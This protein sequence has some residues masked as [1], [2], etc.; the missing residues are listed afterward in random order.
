MK[1]NTVI[2]ILEAYLTVYLVLAAITGVIAGFS[3]AGEMI[4]G[5]E[6]QPV[7]AVIGL[8]LAALLWPAFWGMFAKRWV[9]K[10]DGAS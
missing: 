6:E 3:V 4:A 1:G 2:S 10:D 5:R 8:V 7:A 9:E